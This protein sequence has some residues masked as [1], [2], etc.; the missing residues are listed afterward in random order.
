MKPKSVTAPPFFW[1]GGGGELTTHDQEHC[2][3]LVAQRRNRSL[4]YAV[5]FQVGRI[6]LKC[7][8]IEW[9]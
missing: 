5:N 4:Q 7:D 2:L 6:C 1:G 9:T 3:N 8:G